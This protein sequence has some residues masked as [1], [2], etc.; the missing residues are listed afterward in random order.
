M[1][2]KVP[3]LRQFLNIVDSSLCNAESEVV[4][5]LMK[6]SSHPC[7]LLTFKE[8]ITLL[9]IS[10]SSKLMDVSLTFETCMTS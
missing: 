2:G 9:R 1:L 10:L 6:T 4:K 8:C 5:N 3:V 7:A